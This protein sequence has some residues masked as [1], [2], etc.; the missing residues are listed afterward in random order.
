EL[1]LV[2]EDDLGEEALVAAR[3]PIGSVYLIGVDEEEE[4]LGRSGREPALGDGEGLGPEPGRGL[5]VAPLL[6][7]R[8]E[9]AREAGAGDDVGVLGDRTRA[10]AGGAEDLRERHV[11]R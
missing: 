1:G 10:V 9:A 6:G 4:R 11:V 2:R 8:V 3:R 7:V 5:L